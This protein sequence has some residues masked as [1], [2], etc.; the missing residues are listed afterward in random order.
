MIAKSLQLILYDDVCTYLKNYYSTQ[1]KFATEQLHGAKNV[2]A[3]K[4][5]FRANVV[6]DFQTKGKA[7]ILK[8]YHDLPT[9]NPGLYHECNQFLDKVFL[10]L[11]DKYETDAVTDVFTE[12]FGWNTWL[13]NS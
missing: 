7:R 3:R 6:H 10:E 11:T 13:S 12:H 1:K 5:Q 2:E 9:I 8:P 4:A